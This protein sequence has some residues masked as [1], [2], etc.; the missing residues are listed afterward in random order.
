MVARSVLFRLFLA[1][2]LV[3]NGFASA[4]A[5]LHHAAGSA[6]IG[7][8]SGTGPVEPAAQAATDGAH[9]GC[10]EPDPMGAG[11]ELTGHGDTSSSGHPPDCCEPGTCQGTCANTGVPALP[12]LLESNLGTRGQA[13]VRPTIPSHTAPAL[14]HLM[15]PPIFS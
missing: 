10:D 11:N 15:R 4:M 8:P 14:P 9:A 7:G 2:I 12:S 13:G 5:G 6:A 1:T 3:L